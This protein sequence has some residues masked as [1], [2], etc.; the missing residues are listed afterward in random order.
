MNEQLKLVTKEFMTFFLVRRWNISTGDNRSAYAST[1][2]KGINTI[3][4]SIVTVIPNV[5]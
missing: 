2:A 5:R 3:S 4:E 1:D